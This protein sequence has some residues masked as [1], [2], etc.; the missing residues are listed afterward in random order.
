MA[1][2]R[3]MTVKDVKEALGISESKAYKIIQQ[4]NKDLKAR[5]FYTISGRISE[6][7]LAEHFYGFND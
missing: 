5:G 1:Q 2:T 3:L 4:A 6:K 7:Y